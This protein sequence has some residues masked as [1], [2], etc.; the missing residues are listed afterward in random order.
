MIK[1]INLLLALFVIG[2]TLNSCDKD[3]DETGGSFTIDGTEYSLSQGLIDGW[4]AYYTADTSIY[5]MDLILF[6]S[7][8]NVSSDDI[9]GKGNYIYFRVF[10]MDSTELP[11]GTYTYN[12]SGYT[13]DTYSASGI[14][15]N[16]DIDNQ[17]YDKT[18]AI[19]DGTLIITKSGDTYNLNFNGS[20][21]NGESASLTYKGALDFSFD[22]STKKSAN[23]KKWNFQ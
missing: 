17:T 11:A 4:L 8:F 10:T 9:T 3:D 19:L 18:Y 22:S 15:I 2:L 16:W 23:N 21:S 1:T 14:V 20:D 5:D 13:P 7:G 12:S 6:S